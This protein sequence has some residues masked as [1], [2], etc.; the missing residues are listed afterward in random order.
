[1]ELFIQDMHHAIDPGFS[2]LRF[3]WPSRGLPDHR[4]T[5]VICRRFTGKAGFS[6]C[7]TSRVQQGSE[8]ADT[9]VVFAT[10]PKPIDIYNEIN[11]LE[12]VSPARAR[13]LAAKAFKDAGAGAVKIT[14]ASVFN[15]ANGVKGI[16]IDASMTEGGLT[17]Y[18]RI[19]GLYSSNSGRAVVAAAP[20]RSMTV[21]YGSR[22]MLE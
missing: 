7:I 5:N 9:I 2:G 12:N 6:G 21:R 4:R 17:V 1:M 13:R 11:Q 22:Q 10:D 8:G 19:T 3:G 16:I 20:I 18:L 15:A 14:G